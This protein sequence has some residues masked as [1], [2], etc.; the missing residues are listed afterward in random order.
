MQL[1]IIKFLGQ[2]K[3]QLKNLQYKKVISNVAFMTRRMSIIIALGRRSFRS[4]T[5]PHALART[6]CKLHACHGL[7]S[8]DDRR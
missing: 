3:H 1:Q 5:H 6:H 2:H 4:K 7:E 8:K